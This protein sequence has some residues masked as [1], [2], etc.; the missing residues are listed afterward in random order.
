MDKKKGTAI[1]VIIA[2]V[3]AITAISLNMMDS[4]VKTTGNGIREF[5]GTGDVGVTIIPGN[6]EDKYTETG[7][8]P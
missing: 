3:L 2:I 6:I 5:S 7:E 8:G 4:D 1:L